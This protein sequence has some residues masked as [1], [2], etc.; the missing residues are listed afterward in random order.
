MIKEGQLTKKDTSMKSKQLSPASLSLQHCSFCAH[1]NSPS[2][3]SD[4]MLVAAWLHMSSWPVKGVIKSILGHCPMPPFA[5]PMN[6]QQSGSQQPFASKRVIVCMALEVPPKDLQ[7]PW[8]P[9]TFK[10][11]SADQHQ[12]LGG[13]STHEGRFR[14]MGF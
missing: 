12:H 2:L 8:C 5:F 7:L 1:C 9:P 13:A 6:F 14:E 3:S 4:A 11:V 10:S